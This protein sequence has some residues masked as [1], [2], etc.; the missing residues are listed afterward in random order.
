MKL[1]IML[2]FSISFAS[3]GSNS[4]T[5]MLANVPCT[6]ATNGCTCSSGSGTCC[7]QGDTCARTPGGPGTGGIMCLTSNYMSATP[8]N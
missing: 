3:C 5:P 1:I 8:C 4:T 2:L 7:N 6:G